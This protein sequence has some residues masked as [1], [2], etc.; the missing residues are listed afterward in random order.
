MKPIF[1]ILVALL[2]FAPA[3]MAQEP[4]KPAE[5]SAGHEDVP[6]V[7]RGPIDPYIIGMERSRFLHSA[8]V[9][10]ELEQIE[11]SPE[12]AFA[13]P[14]DTWAVMKRFD[15]NND[16]R[17]DWQE[18]NAYR[19]ALRTA[20]I[21]KYDENGNKKLEGEEREKANRDLAQGKLPPLFAERGAAPRGEVQIQ[22]G[23]GSGQQQNGFNM[24][25]GGQS[26]QPG[27]LPPE[28][29]Q[30]LDKDGDGVVSQAERIE[31]YKF[32]RGEGWNALLGEYDKDGDGK[33]S[34]AEK[35]AVIPPVKII[36]T[37]D[38]L[39]MRDF[40]WDQDGELSDGEWGEIDEYLMKW[41][42][43]NQQRT[44][45]FLDM[46]GDGQVSEVEQKAAQAKFQAMA[47]QLLPKA[48]SWADADGDGMATQEEWMG[49]VD[50]A[51]TAFNEQAEIYTQRFDTDGDGRLNKEERL[52]LMQGLI[53]E[54]DERQR[55]ADTNGD[56]Q[57]DANELVKAAENFLSE[58]GIKP[59][60][61]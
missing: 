1:P 42:E 41:M 44:M 17:I 7:M 46:D 15:K 11:F 39:M 29:L 35:A 37:F 54:D 20:V 18:F 59:A 33:L 52:A 8:G 10:N 57:L 4:E 16:D 53:D 12:L 47:F 26:M 40:D 24:M 5:Q 13:K 30:W 61:K 14:F 45:K 32:V 22:M 6:D 50:R 51:N 60:P 36:M 3:A 25:F 2:I 34:D 56:G 43:V 21:R 23:M 58:W 9:D 38:R 49:L 55:L 31:A 48:M 28:V 27:Q 19:I